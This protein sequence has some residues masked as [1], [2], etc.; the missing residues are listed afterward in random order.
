[1]FDPVVNRIIK[2]IYSQL[3]NAQEK[4][5]AMF[6]VGGFSESI[7]LQQRIKKEFQNQVNVISVPTHPTTATL[8]GATLYGLSLFNSKND[9]MEVTRF[10]ITTRILKYT[11]GI[12]V[13]NYWVELRTGKGQFG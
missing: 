3:S 12:K 1:M 9:N 11:Y 13:R 5:S 6:L 7:Y 10:I 8:R 2:L 4:C